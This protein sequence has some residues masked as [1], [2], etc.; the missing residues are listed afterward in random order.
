MSIFRKVSKRIDLYMQ[1]NGF[2]RT[3]TTFYRISNNIVYCI[4]FDTP[5]ELLYVTAYIMPLY[6]PSEYRYYTYGNRLNAIQSIQLPILNKN[7]NEMVRETWCHTLCESIDRQVLPFFAA[8]DTPN[9]LM[10]YV[11]VH[12][13]A[14]NEHLACHNLHI[15]RLKMYT[16]LYMGDYDKVLQ[17]IASYR[18]ILSS[19]TFL[20]STILQKYGKEIDEVEALIQRGAKSVNE[21]CLG[22][23]SNSKRIWL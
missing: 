13:C 15:Y 16:Y 12:P 5:S 7:D 23:I 3:G 11:D 8:V 19:I 22:V 4:G 1:S 20:T 6:M 2:C 10:Q 18:Q 9:K 17:S 14:S 21:Y